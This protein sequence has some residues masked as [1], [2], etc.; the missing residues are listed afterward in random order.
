MLNKATVIAVGATTDF[1]PTAFDNGWEVWRNS[2]PVDVP[3][4]RL[5]GFGRSTLTGSIG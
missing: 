2:C 3:K 5:V 1:G 4:F